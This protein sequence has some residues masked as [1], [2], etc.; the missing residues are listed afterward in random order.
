M[1]LL[2]CLQALL[3]FANLLTTLV[4]GKHRLALQLAGQR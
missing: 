3:L 2:V 4:L 1:R